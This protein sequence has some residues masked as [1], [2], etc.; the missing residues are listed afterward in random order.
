MRLVLLIIFVFSTY[1]IC[2]AEIGLETGLDIPRYISLKS[3]DTNIRI[4]PSTNYPIVLKFIKK[5]YPLKIIDEYKEWRKIEDFNMNTGWVHKSLISGTRTGIIISNENKNIGLFNTINGIEIGSIG[6]GNIVYL[7]KCK[8]DWCFISLANYRGWINKKSI[9]GVKKEEIY[10][11]S[12]FQ[13]F[14][15]LYWQS[16]N[17]YQE[18]KTAF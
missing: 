6:I 7:E 4:G 12:F 5:N 8:I 16:F 13:I 11:I 3:N 2:V 17:K 15:D 1:K 9:W 14:E 10:K 18:I